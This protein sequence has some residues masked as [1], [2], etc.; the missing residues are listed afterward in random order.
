MRHLYLI[1]IT[2]W[3]MNQ[4]L[5]IDICNLGLLQ[6]PKPAMEMLTIEAESERETERVRGREAGQDSELQCCGLKAGQE[7]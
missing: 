2:Y 4:N 7:P 6:T 5:Y 3:Y 1:Y